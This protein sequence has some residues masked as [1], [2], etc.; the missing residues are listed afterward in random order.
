MTIMN[1]VGGGGEDELGYG[2]G[3]TTLSTNT[4]SY[5][6][7]GCSM[8]LIR[9]T[10]DLTPISTSGGSVNL[11][12]KWLNS[13]D[14]CLTPIV[15]GDRVGFNTEYGDLYKTS[16]ISNTKNTKLLVRI[17][18]VTDAF[19]GMFVGPA[20][21]T[22]QNWTKYN[23]YKIE[24]LWCAVTTGRKLSSSQYDGVFQLASDGT[25]FEVFQG[26]F[27]RAGV[28]S[29]HGTFSGNFPDIIIR[30][31]DENGNYDGPNYVY[32]APINCTITKL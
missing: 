16:S 23:N 11:G 20:V 28:S 26:T 3:Y 25:S 17:N 29:A 27:T 18:N 32:I 21:F 24:G 22:N 12:H 10:C 30:N 13:V 2:V 31:T 4:T 5:R 19:L 14:M 1:M 8:P 15:Q 9:L 7:A 6:L